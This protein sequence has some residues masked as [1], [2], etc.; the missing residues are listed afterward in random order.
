M[1][2]KLSQLLDTLFKVGGHNS[3]EHRPRPGC[4]LRVRSLLYVSTAKSY[5]MGASV[6][7]KPSSADK[8]SMDIGSAIAL[9]GSGG[10]FT[11]WLPPKAT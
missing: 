6:N 9:E 3:V 2:A 10:H 11:M 1:E 4:E 8:N 5:L 7:V